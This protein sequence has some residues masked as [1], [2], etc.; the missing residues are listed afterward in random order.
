MEE[1]I[2]LDMQW[3][4]SRSGHT[5]V[6]VEGTCRCRG[7]VGETYTRNGANDEKHMEECKCELGEGDGKHICDKEKEHAWST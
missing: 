5:C 7:G 6:G 2:C 3:E 1:E 4:G